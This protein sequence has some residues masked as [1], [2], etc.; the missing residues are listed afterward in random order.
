M[1]KINFSNE[2]NLSFDEIINEYKKCD[3][4]NFPSVFEGFGMPIV[5]GQAIGRPVV[6]SNIEPMSSIAGGAACLVDP[7]STESIHQG[8]IK[9]VLDDLYRGKLIKNGLQ[10]CKKY[11]NDTIS[12]EYIDIYNKILEK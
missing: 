1:C 10:N 9:V 8:I 4:V 6:T 2:Y 12:K 11:S 5:E 7:F 3:I